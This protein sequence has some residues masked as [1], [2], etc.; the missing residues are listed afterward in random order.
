MGLGSWV[1]VRVRVYPKRVK[2]LGHRT[3]VRVGVR[4][5]VWVTGLGSGLGLG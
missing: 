5:R 4:V 1:R 2:G 3:W